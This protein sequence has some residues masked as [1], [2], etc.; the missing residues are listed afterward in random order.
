MTSIIAVTATLTPRVR[1]DLITKLQFNRHE[2]TYRTIGNDRAN[3]AMV[4]RAMEH[5]ANS[6]RDT[7]FC[8]PEDNKVPADIK[9]SFVYTDDIKDGGQLVDHLNARVHPDYRS[10]GLVRPYNAGMSRQYRAHVMAL[11]K[12][13][14]IR[15]L[16][17][18]D[19]AGM[20]STFF[21]VTWFPY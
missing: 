17:C 7:D 12:A 10:R 1:E 4:I 19:A 6:F 5:P 9:L 20:V 3:V 16:V 13:G 18:T 2:Y 11:F 15:V 8:V 14:I 21:F